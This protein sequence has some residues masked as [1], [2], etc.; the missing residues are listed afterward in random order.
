MKHAYKSDASALGQQPR[1]RIVPT[2]TTTRA[3][4]PA[5]SFQGSYPTGHCAFSG[6]RSGSLTRGVHPAT[7]DV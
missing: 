2:V 3:I 7:S 5:T 6:R 1:A 4:D